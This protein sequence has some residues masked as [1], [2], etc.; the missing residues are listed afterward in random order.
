MPPLTGRLVVL[1]SMN[2]YK[3]T[4]GTMPSPKS[5]YTFCTL[6]FDNRSNIVYTF[7]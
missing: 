2:P 1:Y 6:A 4:A 3:S 5:K 7:K